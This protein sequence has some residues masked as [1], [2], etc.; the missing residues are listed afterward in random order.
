MASIISSDIAA[1]SRLLQLPREIRDLIYEDAL[2]A[3][4]GI[5]ALESAVINT[6]QLAENKSPDFYRRLEEKFQCHH[7]RTHRRIWSVPTFDLKLG[8]QGLYDVPKYVSMTYQLGRKFHSRNRPNVCLLGAN[9][10]ISAEAGEVMYRRAM[11]SFTGG[12]ALATAFAFLADRSPSALRLINSIELSLSEDSNM[13]GTTAAHYPIM[14]RST[15]SSVLQYAYNHYTDLCTLFS[16]SRMCLRHMTL[17][18]SSN[19]WERNDAPRTA[20]EWL[21]WE[22]K[23]VETQRP[24]QPIWIEP[25]LQVQNLQSIKIYW[26]SNS[27]RPRRLADTVSVMRQHMLKI[28]R[29][30][31]DSEDPRT[32]VP[33]TLQMLDRKDFSGP[34]DIANLLKDYT[35]SDKGTWSISKCYDYHHVIETYH[36]QV[37]DDDWTQCRYMCYHEMKAT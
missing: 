10:Q 35:L 13:S 25:L 7:V 34:C 32:E 18:I 26:G 12:F 36:Q 20:E 2:V 21:L 30:S 27:L 4:N 33:F 24:F 29:R 19:S 1:S 23:E 8:S 28:D 5:I 37:L 31:K 11:F 16:T 3:N 22:E 9:K 17:R 6:S 15:D 14:L